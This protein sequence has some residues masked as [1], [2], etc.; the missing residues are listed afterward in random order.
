M[1]LVSKFLF[2]T[3]IAFLDNNNSYLI[4]SLIYGEKQLDTI[5]KSSQA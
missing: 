4:H 2:Q 1:I 3:I 5:S